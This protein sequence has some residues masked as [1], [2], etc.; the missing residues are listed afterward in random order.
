M[1]KLI[2]IKY[3]ELTTK[4]DN[5]SFFIKTLRDNIKA[6]LININHNIIYD[7]GRMFIETDNFDEVVKV[8]TTTFGIHEINI[9]YEIDPSSI[10]EISSYLIKLLEDKTFKSFKVVTK[11]SD[12]NYPLTSVEIS[13][14]L[15]GLILGSNSNLVVDVH[16][17]EL[18]I[19]IEIRSKKTYI[20]FEK[21]KGLGGYPVGTL[22]KGM[23]MLS[24][25]IDS[26]VAGYLALKRGIRLECVYFESP[27]HTSDAAKNKVLTLAK[28]LFY[29]SGYLKVHVVKFTDIQE[30]IYKNIPHDYMITIMRRM[31]YLISEKLANKNN[32]K[33]IINGESVGQVASQTLTSMAVINEVIKMPVL[34][35]LACF[36]K[37]EIITLSKKIGTYDISILPYEDCCTIFVPDHPVINP[38]SD[39]AIEYESLIDYDQLIKAAI[40]NVETIKISAKDADFE[41]IL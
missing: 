39:V 2:I 33:V 34:R 29:Y 7:K 8:L 35:P 14:K 12:K 37:S 6:S 31:M 9:A 25:G 27:P 40:R 13:K 11:R 15:G 16:N 20:Y 4:K 5:I 22:G 24:G 17:P 26:P 19:N 23:L 3:G 41:N 18:F 32:A 10:E 30:A 38:K 36:D 28:E 21:I 1:K